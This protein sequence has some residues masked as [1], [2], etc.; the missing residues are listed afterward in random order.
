MIII[1]GLLVPPLLMLLLLG[2]SWLED[3]TF[4][5]AAGAPREA[6][7]AGRP[8]SVG[9]PSVQ[10]PSVQASSVQAPSVKAPGPVLRAVPGPLPGPAAVRQAA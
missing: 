10:A 8:T 6:A 7:P 1:L 9:A 2:M 5:P 3:R 4:A